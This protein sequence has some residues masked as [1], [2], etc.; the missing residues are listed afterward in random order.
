MTS[1][2]GSL[3]GA[4]AVASF[5]SS[6]L[7]SGTFGIVLATVQIVTAVGL[8]ML[9]RWAWY[10]A[11]IAV[12]LTVIQGVIGIFGGGFFAFI[13]AGIGLIIP[14]AILVYLLRPQIRTLFGRQT[15]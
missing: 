14:A 15:P 9:K 11:V 2:A 6:N 1:M 3:F 13:C 4:D 5:G 8:L 12:A 10:L 7:W